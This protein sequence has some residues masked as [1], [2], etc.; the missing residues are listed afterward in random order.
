M[1]WREGH[2]VENV[3]GGSTWRGP[4]GVNT[5]NKRDVERGGPGHGRGLGHQRG[6]RGGQRE[7]GGGRGVGRVRGRGAQGPGGAQH[8]VAGGGGGG[9]VRQRSV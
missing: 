6:L 4:G 9:L 3:S 7:A 8:G 1:S 5:A 2:G